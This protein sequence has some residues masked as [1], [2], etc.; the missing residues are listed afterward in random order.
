MKRHSRLQ[1]AKH[2]I[3]TY[4]GK[5]IIKG[6]QRWFGVD[7]SCAIKELKRLDVK[8][9]SHY[10]QQALSGQAQMIASRQKQS[11][12]QKKRDLEKTENFQGYP[13]SEYYFVAG[14]TSGGFP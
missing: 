13:D 1:S 4:A 12:K 6:Y 9:D 5:N 14:Y 3:P 7:L 2:W 8:L 11:E 10:I